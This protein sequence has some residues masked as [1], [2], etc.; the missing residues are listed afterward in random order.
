MVLYSTPE[1]DLCI[2]N[3]STEKNRDSFELTDDQR[4]EEINTHTHTYILEYQENHK[5]TFKED[6]HRRHLFLILTNCV[7]RNM[8]FMS[9]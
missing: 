3:S 1:L 6:K 9:I 2:Q 8:T 7:T 5:L 4:Q